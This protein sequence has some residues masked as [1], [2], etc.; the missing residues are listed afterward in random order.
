[1]E[2]AHAT[3]TCPRC[4]SAIPKKANRCPYCTTRLYSW[5]WLIVAVIVAIVIVALL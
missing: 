2:T 5:E 1:M 4:K 3:K